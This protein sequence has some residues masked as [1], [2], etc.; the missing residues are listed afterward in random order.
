M[1]YKLAPIQARAAL[2]KALRSGDYQ[3]TTN[4]LRGIDIDDGTIK[5]CC[6][7]VACDVFQKTEGIGEW[8]GDNRFLFETVGSSNET[9]LPTEV[10]TWLGLDQTYGTGSAGTAPMK[11]GVAKANGHSNRATSLMGMNDSGATFDDI[12]EQIENNNLKLEEDV[13]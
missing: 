7:G 12:A 4:V 3:Q 9:S 13:S 6:L 11:K 10:A 1:K 5:H 2:A 8:I